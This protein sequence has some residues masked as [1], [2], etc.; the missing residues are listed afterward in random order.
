MPTLG[1]AAKTEA[2]AS[3]RAK[4]DFMGVFWFKKRLGGGMAI[5]TPCRS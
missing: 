2:E 3:R 5:K 4:K 1:V